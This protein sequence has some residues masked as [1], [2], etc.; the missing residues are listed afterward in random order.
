V[1]RGVRLTQLS[2]RAAGVVS[3]LCLALHVV[4]V[5]VG[6]R[7]MLAMSLPMLALAVACASCGWRVLNGSGSP[8]EL[9]VMAA[10]GAAMVV[11]HLS[12]EHGHTDTAGTTATM[13]HATA[14]TVSPAV[15]LVMDAGVSLAALQVGLVFLGLVAGR[16]GRQPVRPHT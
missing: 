16:A 13:H 2:L 10:T 7:D 3:L 1:T 15:N 14:A 8:S 9:I 6:G 11:L 12:I 4:L 5:P